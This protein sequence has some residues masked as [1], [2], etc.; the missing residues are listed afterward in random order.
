MTDSS[1]PVLSSTSSKKVNS[2]DGYNGNGEKEWSCTSCTFLN[3]WAV[4]LCEMCN[5]HKPLSLLCWDFK[6]KES[7]IDLTTVR[8]DDGFP[9]GSENRSNSVDEKYRVSF[10]KMNSNHTW[11]VAST[12]SARKRRKRKMSDNGRSANSDGHDTI[13][14]PK[15]MIVINDT[16]DDENNDVVSKSLRS[17]KISSLRNNIME[18]GRFKSRHGD[19]VQRSSVVQSGHVNGGRIHD[20]EKHSKLDRSPNESL[21]SSSLCNKSKL[22]STLFGS[23]LP[24]TKTKRQ[25]E[26]SSDNIKKRSSR[27]ASGS[28]RQDSWSDLEY[29]DQPINTFKDKKENMPS[30]ETGSFTGRTGTIVA[31]PSFS[32][33]RYDALMK[34]ATVKMK[35]IFGISSLRNLQPTAIESALKGQSQII[36]MAT[37]GGKSLCYQLPAVVL[38]G[39]TVV[40]SPLIALMVDQVEQL[41]KKGVAAELICSSQSQKENQKVMQRLR[42]AALQQENK[43]KGGKKVKMES[44]QTVLPMVKLLYCTPELIQTTR[45]QDILTSLYRVNMLSLIVIDE[46]HCMSTWGHDFRPAYRKLSWLRTSFSNIPCMV[47]NNDFMNDSAR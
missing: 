29:S 9:K 16:D 6:S 24:D 40:V 28:K 37:G 18:T 46:A 8:N 15:N 45:F 11:N 41:K 47:S 2:N 30:T 34:Q 19:Q 5:A 7:V 27:T 39:L 17:K 13:S 1:S 44:L 12:E 4:P 26:P 25:T 3:S 31:N 21:S 42:D 38:P 43:Q 36:I 22:Q 14:N 35:S 20:D 10:T 33:A 32:Q 23:V